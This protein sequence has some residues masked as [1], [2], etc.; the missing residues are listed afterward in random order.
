MR[1]WST[2]SCAAVATL[3][4]VTRAAACCVA[5]S[6]DEAVVAAGASDGSVGVWNAATG[7]QRAVMQCPQAAAVTHITLSP[8]LRLL[9][10]AVGATVSCVHVFEVASAS[11]LASPAVRGSV[12][13]LQWSADARVLKNDQGRVWPTPSSSCHSI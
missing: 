11:L 8:D 4:C 9:A 10:A 13:Q 1:L 2:S 7:L 6:S 12:Q 5:W 3:T